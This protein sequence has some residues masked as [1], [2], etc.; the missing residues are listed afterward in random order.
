MDEVLMRPA[1]RL[2]GSLQPTCHVGSEVAALRIA[3]SVGEFHLIRFDYVI[4]CALQMLRREPPM[5]S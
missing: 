4:G 1:A 5:P 2:A 3:K